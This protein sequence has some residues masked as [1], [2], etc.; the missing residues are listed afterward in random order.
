MEP[1]EACG[2]TWTARPLGRQE[3]W[4]GLAGGLSEDATLQVV[5]LARRLRQR[6]CQV[7]QRGR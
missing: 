2:A 7:G 1:W 5:A 6:G 3:D 4:E